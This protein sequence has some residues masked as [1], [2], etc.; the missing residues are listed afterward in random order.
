M[1][2]GAPGGPLLFFRPRRALLDEAGEE[3]E[4]VGRTLDE[5]EAEARDELAERRAVLDH[6]LEAL[7]RGVLAG[8]VLGEEQEG[9]GDDQ[10]PRRP[11][12]RVAQHR[13]Q[14]VRLAG[15]GVGGR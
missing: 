9:A 5:A 13:D 15:P 8:G 14:L 3:R 7:D 2:E 11:R 12:L 10:P 1:N 6:L 4:A